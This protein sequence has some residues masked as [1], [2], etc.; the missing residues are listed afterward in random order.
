M[1]SLLLTFANNQAEPLET[2]T[3]EYLALGRT[4]TPCALEQQFLMQLLSHATLDEIVHSLILHREQLSLFLYSGHAGRDILLSEKETARAEGIAQLLGQCPNIKVVIL[5]GCSTIGQV[6]KLHKVG[7]PLVIATESPVGDELATRFSKS[8]F[9]ALETGCTIKEAF[10]LGIGAVQ[11]KTEL[12]ICRGVIP[13]EKIMN[14]PLWGIFQNPNKPDASNW[15]LQTQKSNLIG[16]GIKMLVQQTST[17]KE[18]N[19]R[20]LKMQVEELNKD[21]DFLVED[22]QI[23]KVDQRLAMDK[24]SELQF[25]R[26][27][28]DK[29]TKIN[30]IAASTLELET[31]LKQLT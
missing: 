29:L 1:Q 2:L 4:L 27:I 26:I 3:E 25:Q 6:Q 11:A 24:L 5:N 13:R 9:H 31:A 22:I 15:K 7:V 28:D 18:L 23:S 30:Q 16:N 17:A 20:L 14:K 10:D 12:E 21:Y 19:V 8:L